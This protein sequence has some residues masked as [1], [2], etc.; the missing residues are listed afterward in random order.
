MIGRIFLYRIINVNVF[1]SHV[2]SWYSVEASEVHHV[3]KIF[4]LGIF[5]A[6]APRR[7]ATEDATAMMSIKMT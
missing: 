1:A 5:K 2:G 3:P 4:R 6:P 7:N